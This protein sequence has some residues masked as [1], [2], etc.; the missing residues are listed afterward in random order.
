MNE[1]KQEYDVF[2]D[3]VKTHNRVLRITIDKKMA[4]FAGIKAGDQVK[5]YIKKMVVHKTA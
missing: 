3:K 2:Y 5:V 4:A 1:Q